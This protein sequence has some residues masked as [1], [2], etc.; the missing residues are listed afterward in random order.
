VFLHPFAP[1]SHN[2][3]ALLNGLEFGTR[4]YEKITIFTMK[5]MKELKKKK[6]HELHVLHGDLSFC[7]IAPARHRSRSGG[8]L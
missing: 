6:L 7:S 8:S 2:L 1:L 3:P 5:N 4:L